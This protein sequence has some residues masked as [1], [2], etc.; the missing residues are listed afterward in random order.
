MIT[1]VDGEVETKSEEDD[2]QMP[3]LEDACDDNVEYLVEGES[4]V[5]SWGS[6]TNVASTTLVEKLNLPTLKH[7][8]PHK[9]QLLHDY[10]EVKVNKQVLISFSIGRYK[11]EVL[12]DVVPMH[13]GHILLGRPWQFDKKVNHDGFKNRHS[14]VKDN[15]TITLVPLTPRQV[16]ENQMKLKRENDLQKNCDTES[17]K[18]DDE[19]ESERK[20]EKKQKKQWSFYAKASDVKNAFYTNQ[21]IFVLL[22]KEACFNT[23]ELDESLP[24]VVI[25]LLQEYEDMFP[26][27]VPSGL[28]PIRGIEHQIDFVPG[29]TIPNRLAYRSNSEKTK[30]LQRQVEE[31]LTKGHVRESMSSCTVP[32]LLVPKKDGT[33]RMCVDCRAINNITVKYRHPIPRLDD[34]LDEL[35]GSCV[36]TK[37]DLKSGYHQIRMKE[38][39]EWK[40]AFKT[41]YGLYEWLVMRFSLTNAPSTIM[42]LMNHALHAFIGRFVV[43]Y[44]DDILVYS[45][46]LD[47]HI[48]HLH[49]VL[50]FL[51]KEK[52]YANLKKCSFCMDKVVF[53]SY[54]VSAKGIEVDVEKVKAIKEWPT[55]KSITEIKCD[56]SR[57]GIGAVLMQ[58]KRPIA[59][60]SEKLNGAG[61]NYP[62]YDKELY[63]LDGT[64]KV[65]HGKG[66]PNN[67]MEVENSL[68]GDSE[69]D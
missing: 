48:D 39:N 38:G 54:V 61:L 32:V 69:K 56:A 22:Y 35:H 43:V 41:K 37:I 55:P 65:R 49:C 63:A 27:D 46:N 9:L 40:T 2:D 33:W 53:L 10:G 16:Y 62:T 50:A 8:R 11:D 67:N 57:I 25:F 7:P 30:E 44:F 59:Y 24:S 4:L 68:E 31:L 26:N 29:A 1:C 66:N 58:E 5:A 14:F 34:M 51:R 19:K 6:C 21:P 15:K 64:G 17:S 12:C 42:R 18:K 20:K 47:E 60:F 45:K 52:L 36:F 28:P 13:A 3:S 23:N